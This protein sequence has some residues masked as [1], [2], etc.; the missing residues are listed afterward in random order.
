MTGPGDR[1]Y[2][3]ALSSIRNRVDD[4]GVWLAVWEN[5]AE[6]DARARRAANDAVDAIDAALRD[7]HTIRQELISEIRQAD[8]A[9]AERADALL[10]RKPPH[11]LR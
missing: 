9:S 10:A 8:D 6:P 11:D 4:L 5:R 7:L 1:G 2:D 3:D